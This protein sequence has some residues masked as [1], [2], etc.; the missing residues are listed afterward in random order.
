[1]PSEDKSPRPDL[2][3]NVARSQIPAGVSGPQSIVSTPAPPAPGVSGP[4]S[5]AK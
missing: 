3:A 2:L 1:M 5:N 4:A